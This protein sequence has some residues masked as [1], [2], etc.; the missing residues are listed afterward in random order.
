MIADGFTSAIH[1]G[2]SVDNGGGEV[3]QARARSRLL[4]V[5]CALL[6]TIGPGS[7]ALASSPASALAA[8]KPGIGSDLANW[9]HT[10]KADRS[11]E[12]PCYQR[13]VCFGHL[14]RNT[15][16]YRTYQFTYVGVV[17]GMVLLYQENFSKGTT[18]RQVENALKQ[19]LPHDV[20]RFSVVVDRNDGSCGLINVSSPTLAKELSGQ[21]V[22]D[23]QGV[24]GIELQ[25]QTAIQSSVYS[26][27]NIQTATVAVGPLSPSQSCIIQAERRR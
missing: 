26:T 24:V 25:R 22:G 6:L 2:R 10:Y 23:P 11:S 5:L 19:T 27:D 16:N 20:S 12:G 17:D 14:V 4:W 3:A 15:D 7:L 9:K 13:N 8:R 21:K 1:N 18:L